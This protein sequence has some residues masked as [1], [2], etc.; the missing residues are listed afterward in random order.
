MIADVGP[1]METTYALQLRNPDG[2]G[3]HFVSQAE[4]TDPQ[5]CRDLAARMYGGAFAGDD[6]H[7]VIEITR[8]PLSA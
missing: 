2:D 3:F 5:D 8:T 4:Y 7:R 1:T 6:M